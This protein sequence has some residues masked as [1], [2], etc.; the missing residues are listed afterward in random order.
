MAVADFA[1]SGDSHVDILGMRVVWDNEN[2][3]LPDS[4]IIKK[5]MASVVSQLDDDGRWNSPSLIARTMLDRLP[6]V[7]S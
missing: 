7:G 4:N 1:K 6:V 2:V 5:S 3:C